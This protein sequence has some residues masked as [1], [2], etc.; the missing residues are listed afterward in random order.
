[1]AQPFDLWLNISFWIPLLILSAVTYKFV[2][3]PR[4]PAAK[5]FRF[6]AG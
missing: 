3:F 2:E 1:M 6:G 4:I 5:A